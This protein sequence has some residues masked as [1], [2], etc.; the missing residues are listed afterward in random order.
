[1]EGGRVV[2][3]VFS[4]F[5]LQGRGYRSLA[6]CRL[7]KVGEGASRTLRLAIP[8]LQLRLASKLARLRILSPERG[9]ERIVP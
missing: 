3:A 9:E 1:M 6:A 5:S 2:R 4:I 8:P 7:A